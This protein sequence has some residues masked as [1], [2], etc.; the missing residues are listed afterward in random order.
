MSKIYHFFKANTPLFNVI[1]QYRKEK[2]WTV[3]VAKFFFSYNWRMHNKSQSK[4]DV[5][6]GM[7][8]QIGHTVSYTV[9]ISRV[10]QLF[11]VFLIISLFRSPQTE[12][13]V[14]L[15]HNTWRDDTFSA[16]TE[17]CFLYCSLN[18]LHG[19]ASL[20]MGMHS[21]GHGTMSPRL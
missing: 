9:T 21:M 7:S 10:N 6:R 2:I 5:F 8:F 1:S 3:E 4:Q 16:V 20:Y 19:A 17:C 15:V 14:R 18:S 11:F 13:R 12:S